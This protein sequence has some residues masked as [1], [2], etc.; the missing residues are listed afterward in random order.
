MKSIGSLGAAGLFSEET[1]YAP[2]SPY[3]ASKAGADHLVR[4]WRH[5]YGLPTLIT[6][7]SNNYGPY[8]FP[9]KLIPLAIINALD[10]R[11]LPVYGRGDN[12]RDWLF[13]EDH[14]EALLLV[15]LNGAPGAD[16]NIGGSCERP[17]I[18]V[19][20][21]I[22]DLVDELAPGGAGSRR[23]LID[24]VADRPG[25]DQRYAIDASKIR[26]ELGWRPGH[27]FQ[28]GLRKTVEWYLANRPWWEEIRSGVYRGERLG[29]AI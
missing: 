26:N 5:T 10:E 9:E 12:I 16:Y 8:H 29:V 4:A 25:H 21:A 28:G 1:P 3:A 6:N 11:P 2:N 19:V 15:A 13:V 23:R 22:C 24:F 20:E 17:N 18:D 27:D 7:C 14:A